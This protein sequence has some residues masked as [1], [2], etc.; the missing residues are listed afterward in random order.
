MAQQFLILGIVLMPLQFFSLALMGSR[1]DLSPFVLLLFAGAMVLRTG[2]RP[3]TLAILLGF[4]GLHI[5]LLVWFGVAPAYR[6]FSGIVWLGGVFFLLLD[7]DRAQYRQGAVAK[8]MMVVLILTAFYVLYQK[9]ALGVD[10]PG[11][12]FQ[13]PSH[14]GLCLYAGAAAA[15]VALL[16]VRSPGRT[17]FA[18]IALF[19]LL[20][21][22]ALLTLSMH[23]VTFIVTV[24]VV[25]GFVWVP[26]FFSGRRRQ[27]GLR[28][29]AF[30]VVFAA[31]LTY[32]AMQLLT[33]EHFMN[34]IAFANPTNASLLSWLRG[35]DQMRGAMDRSPIFGVGLG[36]TGYFPFPSRFSVILERMGKSNLN[37]TDAYSLM[38]RLVIEIGLPLVLLFLA[39]LVVRLRAFAKWIQFTDRPTADQLAMALNFVWSLA[40]IAGCFLKEP[41]YSQSF[42]YVAAI[43][44]SSV[45]LR[46]ATTATPRSDVA[47]HRQPIAPGG[48]PPDFAPT[49]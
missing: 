10:R 2:I 20:F 17:Q 25:M 35:L 4:F 21:S 45:P 33:M 3:R 48:L 41:L 36:S 9:F 26:R 40:V 7:G 37:L 12:L 15:L 46:A 18:L 32:V 47:T 13:E 49:P 24:S 44:V 6:L 11:A 34:R 38:S 19:L 31:A 16:V 1:F 42:L 14:A 22:A 30:F 8:T 5:I 27:F 43:L 23:I 39:Y 28:S 29:F